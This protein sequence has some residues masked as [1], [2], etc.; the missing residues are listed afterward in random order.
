MFRKTS[1]RALALQIGLLLS[2]AAFGGHANE[3]RN[4]DIN[5]GYFGNVAI[6]G[7]DTVAYF[8]ESSPVRGSRDYTHKWLGAVWHFATK[9]HRDMF[10]AA[11]TRYAPQYG[12]YCAYAAA[13][14]QVADVDVY[15]WRIWKDKLYLNYSPRVRRMWAN[16]IDG[17]IAK[18]DAIWPAPLAND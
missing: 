15:A 3:L 14:G 12:G 4:G 1:I 11:P 16:D 18:A 9:E 2:L 7:Y 6:K 8:T 10:V 13:Q 17:N 5:T